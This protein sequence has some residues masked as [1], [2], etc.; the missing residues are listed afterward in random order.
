MVA[1]SRV[2]VEVG[3]YGRSP[4]TVWPALGCRSPRIAQRDGAQFVEFA[5]VVAVP[6]LVV[7]YSEHERKHTNCIGSSLA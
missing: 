6:G 3:L 7:V 5:R 2:A 4:Q 1:R